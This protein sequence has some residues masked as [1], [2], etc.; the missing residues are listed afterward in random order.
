MYK[1]GTPPTL[2]VGIRNTTSYYPTGADLT[3]G[4]F[5]ST[6]VAEVVNPGAW[7]EINLT[8]Y[9]LAS[10][11]LYA[12]VWRIP[13]GDA[14]NLLAM[15]SDSSSP[16]YSGG[17]FQRSTDSGV[18]WNSYNYTTIDGMFEV[19]GNPI[20]AGQVKTSSV[21]QKITEF[22]NTGILCHKN[23]RRVLPSISCSPLI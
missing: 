23:E 1:N 15:R 10:G 3:S 5:D 21:P 22:L 18:T 4:T 7:Y 19:W 16:T 8:Q 12:I 13:S 20:T 14:S 17:Q 2:T 11:T 6:T 9:T